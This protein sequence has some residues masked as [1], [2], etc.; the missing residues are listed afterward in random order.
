MMLHELEMVEDKKPPF[1]KAGV[2][3][4]SFVGMG[5][6]PMFV[7]FLNLFYAIPGNVLFLFSCILTLVAFLV[8]G[9]MKS[10]LNHTG[11]LR[12]IAETVMLGA[13]AA[14][15]SYFAGLLLEKLV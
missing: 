2:T 12:G 7:Y 5:I 14:G 15:V 11:I 1:R 8:I 10:R 3:Y 13:I 6:V 4:L 9:Y